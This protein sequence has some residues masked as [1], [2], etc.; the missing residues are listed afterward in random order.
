MCAGGDCGGRSV[1]RICLEKKASDARDK[2]EG[3]ARSLKWLRCWLHTLTWDHCLLLSIIIYEDFA[4]H[5]IILSLGVICLDMNLGMNQGSGQMYS[6][7]SAI[8]SVLG[9]YLDQM[10]HPIV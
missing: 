7:R 10:P 1:T 9:Q 2:E 8:G 4:S 3:P 6:L 5:L